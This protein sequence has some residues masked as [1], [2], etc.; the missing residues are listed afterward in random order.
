MRQVNL[1]TA[2]GGMNRL[3]TKA[4]PD[5]A[6]LY[7]LTNGYVTQAGT[8]QSREGTTEVVYLPAGTKGMVPFDGFLHVFSSQPVG[9]SNPLVVV[10]IIPHPTYPDIALA[11]IHFAAPFLEHLYV[12]AEYADTSVHHFWLRTPAVW[13]A[14][15]IYREG[16]SV[17]PTISTGYIYQATRQGD[18]AVPWTPGTRRAINDEVSPTTRNGFQYRAISVGGDAPAS[19]SVEPAW[20]A[21]LGGQVVEYSD[22]SG[23]VTTELVEIALPPG[24]IDRYDPPS[25]RPPFTR[26]Y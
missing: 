24:V 20:P 12:A 17:S 19:G 6:T 9:N 21:V 26:T 23:A 7:E 8:M 11:E 2:K 25:T 13:E 4:G 22:L 18:T 16:E 1:S 5:P 10:N 3:K 15:R 14:N